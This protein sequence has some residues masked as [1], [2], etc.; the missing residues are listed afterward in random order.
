MDFFRTLSEC[1]DGLPG[2]NWIYGAFGCPKL[3]LALATNATSLIECNDFV[4]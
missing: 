1:L 4:Y 3:A 2:H